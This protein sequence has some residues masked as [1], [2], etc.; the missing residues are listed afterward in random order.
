MKKPPLPASTHG[1]WGLM[2]FLSERLYP[3]LLGFGQ[4]D[5]FDVVATLEQLVQEVAD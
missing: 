5:D 2:C 3:T 1:M 4:H